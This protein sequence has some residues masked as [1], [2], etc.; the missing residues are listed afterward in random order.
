M[1]IDTVIAAIQNVKNDFCIAKK[2][3]SHNLK[4]IAI[5]SPNYIQES[6]YRMIEIGKQFFCRVRHKKCQAE[7][8]PYF[9]LSNVKKL[10]TNLYSLPFPMYE[11]YILR[12]DNFFSLDCTFLKAGGL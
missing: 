5:F 1:S 4:K 9:T 3:Q 11:N 12:T 7:G 8:E 10:F 2:N 6:M